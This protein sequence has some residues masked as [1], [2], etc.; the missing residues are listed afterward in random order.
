[1]FQKKVSC[2]LCA[3]VVGQT[4]DHV[5]QG[6]VRVGHM[7]KQDLHDISVHVCRIQHVGSTAGNDLGLGHG[8]DI[9][10]ALGM[11]KKRRITKESAPAQYIKVDLLAVLIDRVYTH[12]AA[13]DDIDTVGFVLLQEDGFQGH[14]DTPVADLFK[15]R[16]H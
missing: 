13:F 12:S 3:V 7:R 15:Q 1:M 6:I 8:G 4:F 2:F 9:Y 5:L 14:I 10:G 16:D 11:G